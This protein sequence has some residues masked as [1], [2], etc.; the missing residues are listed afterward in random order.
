MLSL[1]PIEYKAVIIN[2]GLWNP[3]YECTFEVETTQ[4]TV[5]LYT[6][7]CRCAAAA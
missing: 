1:S 3:D 2:F 7:C 5:Y 6:F 4:Q